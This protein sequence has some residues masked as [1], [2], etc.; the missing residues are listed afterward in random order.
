MVEVGSRRGWQL[1]EHSSIRIGDLL[2]RVVG[3]VGTD[4]SAET[5]DDEACSFVVN[6]TPNL[7]NVVA[8]PW[9]DVVWFQTGAGGRAHLGNI[10]GNGRIG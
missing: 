9:R 4:A 6:T 5:K 7:R 8:P 1:I 2:A 3:I 10:V